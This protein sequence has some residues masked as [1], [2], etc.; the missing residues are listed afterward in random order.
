M[1]ARELSPDLRTWVVQ[2]ARAG[3][4]PET[5]LA[6]LL[7]SGWAE[8]EAV[9]ALELAMR[10]FLERHAREHDLPVPVRVP[11]PPGL[12]DAAEIFADGHRV[13]VLARMLLP[14]VILFAGLLTAGE[15]AQLIALARGG[16]QRSRVVGDGT[17]GQVLFEG[18]TSE[19]TSFAR[20]ANP[21]CARIERRIAALLDWPL[22]N[23]EGLQVLRYLPGG[24]YEPHF[25]FFVPDSPGSAVALARGGQ[26]VA[27]LVMYLNTPARGGA[28]VFPDVKLEIAAQ[29]G[30]G[31][32]FSYD[33][34]HALTRTLHG[35]APVLE[36]EK[37]IATLWMR[38]RRFD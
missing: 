17:G 20:G 31:V 29:R 9:G 7:Q 15:C 8:D 11:A 3:A 19:G 37:W 21:L 26:R 4:T 32:F 10:E 2:Q 24:R 27:S 6:P 18:R 13:Q 16:L 25:D 30:H 1:S 14:R 35:G 12:D 23:G 33:R 5:L 36:G 34:P 28:T 38:E 22:E